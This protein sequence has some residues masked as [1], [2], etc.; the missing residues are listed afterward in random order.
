MPSTR[1]QH[2]TA[3]GAGL[4]LAAAAMWGLLGPVSRLAF[5]EGLTPMEV[6]F[7]RAFLGSVLFGIHAGVR[8]GRFPRK[9]DVPGF[10]AFAIIGGAVFFGS[11]QLAV[12]AGGAA[13]AAV[14]L[15]TA[16]AWVAIGSVLWL[17]ERLTGMK[18]TAV[19]VTLLGV[20]LIASGTGD[21][22]YSVSAI[23]WGLVAG[24]SYA[25]YYIF[26]KIYFRHYSS[27]SVYAFV[28]PVA[29][30]ALLPLVTFGPKTPAVVVALLIIGLVST[31][32]AYLA[33]A[34]GLR[35]LEASRASIIATS[36]PVIAGAI[37][38]AWWGERF[39]WSGYLGALLILGA[40]LVMTLAR[41]RRRTVRVPADPESAP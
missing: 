33:Y 35:R 38:F 20:A 8:G 18:V 7:W 24:I 25:S 1:S 10:V 30:I 22:R 15:Y 40:V 29:A 5:E 17:R 41:R 32:F 11:Y 12:A 31:Y 14:L 3:V 6:A 2:S 37:A 9:P 27:A 34:A 21:V 36:E 16:P 13:L 26:G 23:A 39:A 4:V 19:V 28:F